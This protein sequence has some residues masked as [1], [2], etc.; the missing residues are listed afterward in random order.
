[1]LLF[2]RP[3]PFGTVAF[4]GAVKQLNV[5]VHLWG[6]DRKYAT[7]L[8]RMSKRISLGVFR[9]SRCSG[10]GVLMAFQEELPKGTIFQLGK[11]SHWL[12][13]SCHH[14]FFVFVFE[15]VENKKIVVQWVFPET[16]VSSKIDG[17]K[18][19]MNETVQTSIVVNAKMQVSRMKNK[20][21]TLT[22]EKIFEHIKYK[23]LA[24]FSTRKHPQIV[25]IAPQT[26]P[27]AFFKVY[28]SSN[29]LSSA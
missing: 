10:F 12:H 4:Y 22:L 29:N 24:F 5:T 15:A 14:C 25:V 13:T 28:L 27:R 18:S 21:V 1:M 23:F 16:I 3:N 9:W 7:S 26:A 8:R 19:S 6:I 20:S 11:T 2:I 17:L